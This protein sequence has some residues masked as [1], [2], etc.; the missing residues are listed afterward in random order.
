MLH[1]VIPA[2]KGVEDN[3]FLFHLQYFSVANNEEIF[4]DIANGLIVFVVY[5]R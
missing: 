1:A 3:M 2:R 4:V 5:F